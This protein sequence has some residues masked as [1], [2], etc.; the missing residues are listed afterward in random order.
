[1]LATVVP[2]VMFVRIVSLFAE[3]VSLEIVSVA[4]DRD[5]DED[6]V[7]EI[8]VDVCGDVSCDEILKT[9]KEH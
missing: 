4:F 9:K 3:M 7:F 8:V 1:M 2:L 5:A 6:V